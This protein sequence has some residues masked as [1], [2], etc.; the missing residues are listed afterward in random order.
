MKKLIITS[1]LLAFSIIATTVF[2]P[3]YA[4]GTVANANTTN[5]ALTTTTDSFLN[6]ADWPVAPEI[7][8][9]AA[10][11]IEAES[12]VVLYEKNSKATMY[13]A[14]ITKLMTALLV[15]ENCSLEEMVPFSQR[16]FSVF[17]PVQAT[18]QSIPVRNFL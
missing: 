14:S 7:F 5:E 8:G 13:P 15:L 18:L 10:L 6:V 17:L 12:G 1:F 16:L 3:I 4:S 11:L 2:S 9:E